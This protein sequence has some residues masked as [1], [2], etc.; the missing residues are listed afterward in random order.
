MNL[1]YKLTAYGLKEHIE[2]LNENN[3]MDMTNRTHLKH[4]LTLLST[5]L[6]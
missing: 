2:I 4:N 1:M 3:E 6:F 5:S